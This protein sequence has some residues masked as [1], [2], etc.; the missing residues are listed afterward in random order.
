MRWC[1]YVS[2]AD[3]QERVA[4]IEGDS[5]F[6]LDR[7]R[8]LI[9]L[10]GDDT[11]LAEAAGR[12]RSAP[13]EVVGL[14]GADL[15]APVPV[16]PS[17]RDFI[18]FEEHVRNAARGFGREVNPAW[19]ENPLFYFTNPAAVRGPN[20]PVAV[21][22]G[23]EAFDYELEI[24]MVIGRPGRD[25]DPATALEHIAGLMVFCDWSARDLQ[26][27]EQKGNLGP[28][29]GK[30]TATSFGPWLLTRDELADRRAGRAWDLEMTASVNGRCYSHGNLS[31]IYWSPGQ[32]LAYASRGT[33]LRS[34]DVIGTGTVGTGCIL[35]LS[36][37][38]GSDAYPWLRAGDR[39]E[40]TV[41]LLG[42][43]QATVVAGGR[44]VPLG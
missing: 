14:A 15:R 20:D 1:T 38:H 8:R 32:I 22:P 44:P 28:A 18:A 31:S 5:L 16:P 3:G 7:P 40:L 10:L 42:S 37:V 21:A 23:S 17:I 24:A 35:E 2:P 11:A 36:A 12:A 6:G 33:E 4:L 39:V 27:R 43:I 34:G 9:D 26:S 19:Y 30:D 29:K 41:D 13:F 25:L